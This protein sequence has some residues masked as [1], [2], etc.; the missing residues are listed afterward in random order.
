MVF[1]SDDGWYTDPRLS[2]GNRV[3]TNSSYNWTTATYFEAVSGPPTCVR[4]IFLGDRGPSA[5]WDAASAAVRTP[6]KGELNLAPQGLGF[7]VVGNYIADSRVFYCPSVG[8]SMPVPPNK[9]CPQYDPASWIGAA[10]SIGD[11]QRGA[12]GFDAK[13]ILYGDWKAPYLPHWH[14]SRDACRAILCDYAYRN[15]PVSVPGY[16]RPWG[17]DHAYSA[18][19]WPKQIVGGTKPGVPTF[20]ACPPFKTQKLLGGRAIVADSF[21]RGHPGLTSLRHDVPVGDGFYAHREGYNVL[22]GDWHVKWY[23]D[24]QEVLMWSLV[25]YDDTVANGLMGWFWG[26]QSLSTAQSGLGWWWWGD[27]GV[28]FVYAGSYDFH[29]FRGSGTHAWHMLDNNAGIDLDPHAP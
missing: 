3:R 21:G 14:T 28:P 25:N 19:K 1:T 13:S 20:I 9:Y 7:L 26:S 29:H 8:G 2:S 10:K 22:Y 12:G 17:W 5:V 27:V 15:T 6:V 24:P 11:L 4:T 16:A 18:D 23:G